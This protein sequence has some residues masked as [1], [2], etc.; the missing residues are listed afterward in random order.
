MPSTL[1]S[2]AVFVAALLATL[3]PPRLS[4][5]QRAR[6][7]VRLAHRLGS[8]EPVTRADILDELTAPP[9]PVVPAGGITVTAAEPEPVTPD[10]PLIAHATAGQADEIVSF[11]DAAVRLGVSL[12]TAKRYAAP[13]SGRLIRLGSG[14]SSASLEALAG[15]AQ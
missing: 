6:V 3:A 9:A 11:A 15:G 1:S 7:I 5:L 13:S 12:S 10:R 2:L 4:P 8:G 14:V